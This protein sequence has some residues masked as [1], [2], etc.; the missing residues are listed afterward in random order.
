MIITKKQLIEIE[1]ADGHSCESGVLAGMEQG[2]IAIRVWAK[3]PDGQMFNCQLELT[4]ADFLN[5]ICEPK[6]DEFKHYVKLS[7]DKAFAS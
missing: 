2:S 4:S 6:F 3:Q 1:A 5:D 7:F